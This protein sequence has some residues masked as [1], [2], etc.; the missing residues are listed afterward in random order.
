MDYIVATSQESAAAWIQRPIQNMFGVELP[1]HYV[2][3]EAWTWINSPLADD[4]S[5]TEGHV[6]FASDWPDVPGVVTI[7]ASIHTLANKYS[8]FIYELA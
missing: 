5:I 8:D 2:A 7:I 6:W 1:V 3:G 4:G